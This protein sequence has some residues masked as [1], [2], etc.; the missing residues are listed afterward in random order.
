M[1]IS[2]NTTITIMFCLFISYGIYSFKPDIMFD[3]NK[4]FKKFGLNKEETI[5][6]FWLVITICCFIF[7]SGCLLNTSNYI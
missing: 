2:K 4:N 6:P 3:K 7:Y 1:K 5:Y